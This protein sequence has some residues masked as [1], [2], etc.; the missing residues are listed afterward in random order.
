MRKIREPFNAVSHLIG[1]AT[2]LIGMI[3][4]LLLGGSSILKVLAV[5][6]YSLGLFSLLLSS[7]LYHAAV[8]SPQRTLILRKLDHSAIYVLIAATYTPFCLIAFSG[9]YQWGIL[10]IIWLLALTGII[11]KVWIINTPRWLTAGIYILMGWL[12]IFAVREMLLRIPPISLGWLLAGGI[13]YTIGAV[14][15]ITKRG[16][17]FPGVFG[18]HELWHVFVLLGAAAHFVSVASIL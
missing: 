16:N 18:F 1:A 7:G 17:F 11:V 10:S 4:L 5:V 9:F 13:I 6:I 12:C 15:Y 3:V 14:I 8:T 2:A